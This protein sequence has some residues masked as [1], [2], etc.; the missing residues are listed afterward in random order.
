MR[1]KSLFKRIANSLRRFESE[2]GEVLSAMK[3]IVMH[4][5]EFGLY[6]YAL[7]IVTHVAIMH[8]V[9]K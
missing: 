6:L 4:L 8:L 5:A 3:G 9:A 2:L 1:V 7:Y